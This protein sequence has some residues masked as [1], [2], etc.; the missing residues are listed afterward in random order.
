MLC[1]AH[2]LRHGAWGER[3]GAGGRVGFAA[4]SCAI[5]SAEVLTSDEALALPK[6]RAGAAHRSPQLAGS[7]LLRS[8]TLHFLGLGHVGGN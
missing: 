8:W 1:H 4:N 6:R 2:C 3:G 7:Y 5:A